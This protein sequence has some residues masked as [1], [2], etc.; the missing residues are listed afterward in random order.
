MIL[1]KIGE[2]RLSWCFGKAADSHICG[3]SIL[4]EL[5][6]DSIWSED[7]SVYPLDL[8]EADHNVLAMHEEASEFL[9]DYLLFSLSLSVSL[10]GARTLQAEADNVAR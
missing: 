2:Y 7:R 10:T 9:S 3:F 1:R 6:V 4:Q 8:A 5:S